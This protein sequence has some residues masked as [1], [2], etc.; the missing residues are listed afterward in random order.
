MHFL[1]NEEK[2][3]W[4]EYYVKRETGGA[5]KRVEDA[6]TTIRQQQ[7]DTEE[8]GNAVLTTKE[9]EK[10]FH[11]MLVAIGDSLSDIASS[12]DGADG[13]D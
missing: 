12:D 13:E 7:E 1:R 3:K 10:I 6:E 5:R 4:I 2:E 11:S 8:A 9:P